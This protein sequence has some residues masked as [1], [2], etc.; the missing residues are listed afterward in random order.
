MASTIDRLGRTTNRILRVFGVELRRVVKPPD[1]AF[2]N[3]LNLVQAYEAR[4]NEAEPLIAECAKRPL[5]L[6]RMV[7]TP[8]SEAYYLVQALSRSSAVEGDICEFGVAEGETSALLATEIAAGNKMLHL[9]DSFEG[10]PKPTAKDRLIDDIFGLGSMEAYTGKMACP[11]DMV[12]ARLAAVSFPSRRVVIHKGFV[13]HVF[14]TDTRLPATVS[15]AYVDFDFYEPI[16]QVL[17]FLHDRTQAGAVIIVDDYGYF[18]S[19]AKS[20]VDEFVAAKNAE[21]TVY[22]CEVPKPCYG[23]FAVLTRVKA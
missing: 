15:F 12:Q 10:L 14:K 2:R 5:L 9:F 1:V 20:A 4:L 3:F 7:G 22:S 18:S 16:L 13:D 23:S 11:E 6:A 21:T 19:G 8:P 17:A